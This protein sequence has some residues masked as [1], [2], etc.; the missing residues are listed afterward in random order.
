MAT[1]VSHF[2]FDNTLNDAVGSNTLSNVGTGQSFSDSVFRKGTHALSLDGSG[3]VRKASQT[4]INTGNADLSFGGWFRPTTAT[5][6]DCLGALGVNSGINNSC[7]WMTKLS[8]TVI[9]VDLASDALSFT[10]PAMS[11]ATFYWVWCEYTAASKTSALYLDNTISS[12][13]AQAHAANL[14]L[15]ATTD[16]QIGGD[17]DDNSIFTGYMDDWRFYNGVTSEA[18][19]TAIYNFGAGVKTPLSSRGIIPT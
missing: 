18:E 4:G 15:N 6:V 10:V 3:F 11:N 19:R 17:P 16:I 2:T 9:R 12:S 1:L 14:A 7:L 5:D 13:G 8:A